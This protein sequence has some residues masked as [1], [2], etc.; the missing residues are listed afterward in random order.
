[1]VHGPQPRPVPVVIHV[2][3]LHHG[4]QHNGGVLRHIPGLAA[5]REQFGYYL[6]GVVKERGISVLAE[7]LNKDAL[8]MFHAPE[9]L[10]E[11]VAGKLGIAHVFCEPDLRTRSSLGFTRRLGKKHHF[12]R[13]RLW[14]NEIIGYKGQRIL[15]ICGANHVASFTEFARGKGQ[16]VTVLTSY[17]GRGFFEAAPAPRIPSI[18]V[19]TSCMQK[20]SCT[21]DPR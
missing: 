10:A 9:S 18:I 17:Y 16:P 20:S 2:I 19:P 7:E 6:M 13:E 21:P 15:F 12:V 4:I 5:L 8:A 14:Y 11:S 3:G 1:M